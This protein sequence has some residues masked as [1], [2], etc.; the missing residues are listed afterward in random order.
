MEMAKENK[1]D[2]NSP[3]GASYL[4]STLNALLYKLQNVPQQLNEIDSECSLV[5]KYLSSS[6]PN[7]NNEQI[8][9]LI[10]FLEKSND[11]VKEILFSLLEDLIFKL[12]EPNNFLSELLL[13]QDS[14]SR[15]L[16]AKLLDLRAIPISEQTKRKLYGNEAAKILSHY[17]AYTRASYQ[18]L[19][20]LIPDFAKSPPIIDSLK[21]CEKVCAR[22]IISEVIAKLGWKAVNYGLSVKHYIG[23]SVD[24]SLPFYLSTSE[25]ILFE[26]SEKAERISDYYLFTAQGGMSSDTAK[27][28]DSDENVAL[29]RAYNLAH[30]NLLQQI[31]DVAPLTNQKVNAIIEQMDRIVDEFIKLFNSYSEECKILPDIYGRIKNMIMSGL[32]T[33]P[34]ASHLSADV[35]RLTQMFEDPKSIGEVHTLHGLK[36][37]LHQR[38]L[39]LGFKLV[40]QAKS[41]NQ[42]ISLVLASGN[43][44]LSVIKDINYADFE[45]HNDKEYVSS[46]ITYPIKAVIDGFVRQMLHGHQSFPSVNIFCYG[47]EVHYFVWFRN[48]P[49]FIRIDFSPPL[50]GGMIDLQYFGVSNYEISDHPNIYLDAIR[51][52]FV[53]LEFDVKMEG[54]HIQARYDKERALDLSQLCERVEYLFCLVPYLMDLDWVVGSLNLASDAKKKVVK[55]WAELFSRWGVLPINKFLTQDR[56]SIL[57]DVLSTPEGEY[58]LKWSG[59]GDY[60]DRYT[61]H[62]STN[63]FHSTFESIDTLGLKIP[64]FSKEDMTQ[65]GQIN[66]EKGLLNYFKE[67]LVVGE[68]GESETGFE[69]ASEKYFRKVHEA[70]RFAE[71]ISEAKEEFESSVVLAKSIIP[72]EQIV[73]FQDTGTL[74]NFRIQSAIIFLTGDSAKLFVLRD[75]AG[76]IRMAFFIRGNVLC[77]RWNSSD[78]CWEMNSSSSTVEFISL[79][80][81]NNYAVIGAAPSTNLLIEETKKIKDE[82]RSQYKP[83]LRLHTTGEKIVTGLRA[84]PGRAT[85]RVLLGVE[86]RL[87]EDF[88]DYIFVASAVSPDENTILFHSNGII[89]TGGGILS[90]AGLIAT[91]FHKPAIIISGK[92]KREAEGSLVLLYH[93][94]EYQVEHK[95]E[96]GL[97]INIY[98]DIHEKEHEMRDGDLVVVDANEGSLEVLGQETD[99]IALFEGLKALGRTNEDTSRISDVKELLVLRGK[100]LHIRHKVEKI[101]SRISEPLIAKFIIREIL[102]GKFLEENKSTPEEKAFLIKLILQNDMVGMSAAYYLSQTAAEVEEKYIHNYKAAEKNIRHAQYPFEI[103]IPRLE[104][105]RIY[106]TLKSIYNSLKTAQLQTKT[107]ETKETEYINRLSIDRLEK[108]RKQLREKVEKASGHVEKKEFLRHL[109]RQ[110]KRVNLLL[111]EQEIVKRKMK[112]LYSEFE[113]DDQKVCDGLSEKYILKPA[114]GAIELVPLIGWKAANL[115][116]LELLSGK[117]LVPHW[118]AVSDKAFQIVLNTPIKHNILISGENLGNGIILLE[119]IDKIVLRTDINNKEKSSHIRNLWDSI[120][121]PVEI[122]NQVIQAYREIEK[123]FLS[124]VGIKEK[125]SGFYVALRSSSCEEDAEIAARA[126]EFETYLFITGEDLLIEYLKRTWGGLWTERAIHNRTVFGD[127]EIKTKGG[128]IVQRIVWS[129]V[130]GVLQTINVAKGDLKEIVINAGLGLG[131]GVVS[132]T[133]AADQIIVSKEGDL[134]KGPL[135]FNYITA[136]KTEQVVFNK[137][138]GFGTILTPTL[139]HQRF[140]P[141]LD[142]V[143]LC[144][145]VSIA[146][147]L[148]AAYGYPL[149][150]EFA[151]EGTR[152]WIL[153]VRPVATFLPAFKETLDHYPILEKKIRT[154]Q[155]KLK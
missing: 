57:Q 88:D 128:V 58:E 87:P 115:S 101:I 93:T 52:F 132:G 78:N 28:G 42:S 108:L 17:L 125:E 118:F 50:Q 141:A 55:A 2:K 131:E 91:Q 84:S 26:K 117:G 77:E 116:E 61:L 62:K 109:F 126:G 153:Q 59:D 107:I 7:F 82:L 38:G 65:F 70:D 112:K 60:C 4:D 32:E 81:K 68:I 127:H 143:E 13:S 85:G 19:L 18:D 1:P 27:S 25:A 64:K 12:D 135:H 123:E 69:R 105:F 75:S 145:L 134:E 74:E 106:Q 67:A 138:M 155:E 119:A 99:T 139:Y 47:N 146:F 30:A 100:K 16:A 48:H 22:S 21:E 103:V 44:I 14:Q 89:A 31:L 41:P 9:L 39:Q 29:F 8:N 79:L 90:H 97:N 129:R 63:F 66:L 98:Y 54:T 3:A 142:Y 80:R 35:T 10:P 121:I 140:R 114:E 113:I 150:I 45:S 86:G 133:V 96:K 94:L 23:V 95:L 110:L 73:K 122:R 33:E 53:N 152:L 83:V 36:R 40:D 24:G 34:A 149:D 92:W 15:L 20:Y 148:E 102:I 154:T 5:K 130:S 11:D 104:V 37:Y 136:D 71:I 43:K 111:N 151:I 51:Y 147:R 144:E 120:S 46:E 49:V 72:L 6:P 124:E 56:L 76:I 137:R